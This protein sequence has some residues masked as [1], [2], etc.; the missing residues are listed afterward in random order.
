MY[1]VYKFACRL[2]VEVEGI[3]LFTSGIPDQ[4]MEVACAY[5]EEACAGR[6]LKLHT[7]LFNVDDYDANGAI[8]GRYANITSTAEVLRGLAHCT[9]GRFH[10]IRETGIIE[11]DDISYLTTE[12]DKAINFS[13]KCAMLVESVKKKYD[14]PVSTGEKPSIYNVVSLPML[15]LLSSKAQGQKIRFL[16]TI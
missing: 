2:I 12:I 11:S 1:S 6:S 5:L 7:T 10:W 8:P 14:K 4:P 3:Y 15:R 16:K 9:H 13:K